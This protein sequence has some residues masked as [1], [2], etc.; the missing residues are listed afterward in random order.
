MK[1]DLRRVAILLFCLAWLAGGAGLAETEEG[2]LWLNDVVAAREEILSIEAPSGLAV[3][4][5][6]TA[7][8]DVEE[9][10]RFFGIS[11]REDVVFQENSDFQSYF[12]GKE[13][14]LSV[15]GMSVGGGQIYFYRDGESSNDALEVFRRPP[16]PTPLPRTEDMPSS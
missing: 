12:K 1:Q 3:Y 4:R 14:L 2:Y 6:H 10:A 16:R 5:A 15:G 7:Q 8:S 13:I 9:I 11:E